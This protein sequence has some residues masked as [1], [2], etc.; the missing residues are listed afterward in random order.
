MTPSF[1]FRWKKLHEIVAKMATTEWTCFYKPL[2][3][4]RDKMELCLQISAINLKSDR[5]YCLEK[6]ASVFP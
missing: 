6:Q 2:M 3:N 1:L 4:I 5:S